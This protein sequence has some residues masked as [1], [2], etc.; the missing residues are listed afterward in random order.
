LPQ[1]PHGSEFVFR[2]G[3]ALAHVP[4]NFPFFFNITFT[5]IAIIDK[6]SKA[7]VTTNNIY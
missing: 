5:E 1:I 3:L 6:E 2:N 4:E 7:N